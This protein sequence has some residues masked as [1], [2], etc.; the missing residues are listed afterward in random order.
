LRVFFFSADDPLSPAFCASLSLLSFPQLRPFFPATHHFSYLYSCSLDRSGR[1]SPPQSVESGI[2]TFFTG[3]TC[4]GVASRSLLHVGQ[5]LLIGSI[6]MEP[7]IWAFPPPFVPIRLFG[8]PCLYAVGIL[9]KGVF[10]LSRS[11]FLGGAL[12]YFSFP[13]LFFYCRGFVSSRFPVN[14]GVGRFLIRFF[15]FFDVLDQWPPPPTFLAQTSSAFG[16]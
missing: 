9:P 2:S 12:V 1:F 8:N 11:Y 3:R 5:F 15:F 6:L 14:V 4:C 16:V 7:L 10:F 13:D